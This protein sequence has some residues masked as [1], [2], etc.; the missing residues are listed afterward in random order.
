MST[1][2]ISFPCP[3]TTLEKITFKNKGNSVQSEQ[4]HV[5]SMP[6]PA[7]ASHECLVSLLSFHWLFPLFPFPRAGWVPRRWPL[8]S[9][10]FFPTSFL[11]PWQHNRS[12][13]LYLLSPF[14][15][16]LPDLSK[17]DCKPHTTCSAS[18]S[19]DLPPSPMLPTLKLNPLT[20]PYTKPVLSSFVPAEFSV[21]QSQSP[22]S[23]LTLL[24][25]LSSPTCYQHP[26]PGYFISAM[27]W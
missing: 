20:A 22:G 26:S 8:F 15:K 11:L 2:R 21:T 19:G 27:F 6:P 5:S 14:H 4:V 25:V 18:M 10:D 17:A 12:F 9:H 7:A 13:F 1:R 24:A 16:N 23:S 3:N